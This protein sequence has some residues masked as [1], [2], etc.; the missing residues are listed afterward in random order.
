MAIKTDRFFTVSIDCEELHIYDSAMAESFMAIL[1]QVFNDLN[2]EL[3][4]MA[5]A[6]EEHTLYITVRSLKL[7]SE[8]HTSMM[9]ALKAWGSHGKH[10][11]N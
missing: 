4:G 9:A 11:N 7:A 2:I 8:I 5:I 10:S 6:G 1:A 3:L